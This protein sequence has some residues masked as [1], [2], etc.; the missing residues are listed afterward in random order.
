MAYDQREREV[1][2]A[3]E[4]LAKE[5]EREVATLKERAALQ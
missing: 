3:E 1:K 4:E 5:N 2:R